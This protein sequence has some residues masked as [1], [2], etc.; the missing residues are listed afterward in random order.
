[1]KKKEKMFRKKKKTDEEEKEETIEMGN[2]YWH[3]VNDKEN[4]FI[5]W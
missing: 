2:W 1:M 3:D 5:K 4:E